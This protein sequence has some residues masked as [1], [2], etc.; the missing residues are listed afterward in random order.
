MG[1][2]IPQAKMSQ[3]RGEA[4][5]MASQEAGNCGGMLGDNSTGSFEPGSYYAVHSQSL[6]EQPVFLKL[7]YRF[8]RFRFLQQS[9]EVMNEWQL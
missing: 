2:T 6:A 7:H 4:K 8:K 9:L 5:E 3:S 1:N